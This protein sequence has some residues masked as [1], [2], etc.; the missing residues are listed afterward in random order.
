[1]VR[2]RENHLQVIARFPS[3]GSFLTIEEV[4]HEGRLICRKTFAAAKGKQKDVAVFGEDRTEN[5]GSC[6]DRELA[7]VLLGGVAAAVIEEDGRKRT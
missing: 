5:L 6:G 2:C 4:S 1:M 3:L 7:S